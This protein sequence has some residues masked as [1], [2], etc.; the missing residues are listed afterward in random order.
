MNWR[1]ERECVIVQLI[2]LC[3]LNDILKGPVLQLL[4]ICFR[5]RSCIFCQQ[6]VRLQHPLPLI[7]EPAE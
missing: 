3:C 2:Y 6:L 1:N 7:N 4:P 5:K